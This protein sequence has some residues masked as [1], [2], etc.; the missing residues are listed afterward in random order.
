L[1][2]IAAVPDPMDCDG[3]GCLIEQ[4]AM[5]ADTEAEETFVL[6]RKSFDRFRD[7]SRR[8]GAGL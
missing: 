5:I 7:R 6:A 3:I 8:S 2:H 4:H 1:V